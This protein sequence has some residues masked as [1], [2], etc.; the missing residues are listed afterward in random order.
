MKT[1]RWIREGAGPLSHMQP[2][3][4]VEYRFKSGSTDVQNLQLRNKR[5]SA[6]KLRSLRTL[7]QLQRVCEHGEFEQLL[8]LSEQAEQLQA[9]LLTA[10]LQAEQQPQYASKLAAQLL[11]NNTAATHSMVAQQVHAIEKKAKGKPELDNVELFAEL[12]TAVSFSVSAAQTCEHKS[13]AF[14]KTVKAFS[15][16]MQAVQLATWHRSGLCTALVQRLQTLL[17]ELDGYSQASA[18]DSKLAK[19]L[20]M[21]AWRCADTVPSSVFQLELDLVVQSLL[22]KGIDIS[23]PP[24]DT[25]VKGVLSL[26]QRAYAT[27]NYKGWI[28]S[29]F[30]LSS[31]AEVLAL[32]VAELDP[33]LSALRGLSYLAKTYTSEQPPTCRDSYEKI[34][35]MYSEDIRLLASNAT[36]ST[37]P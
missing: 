36:K 24:K 3:A 30:S 11:G 17:E 25:W 32:N 34:L 2:C 1:L 5:P 12:D 19:T 22:E 16:A 18:A 9:E 27:I 31:L 20:A 33:T 37:Q 29:A 10:A 6:N 28:D 4:R 8:A 23:P 14:A 13:S 26:L 21:H 7:E 35:Q 15:G